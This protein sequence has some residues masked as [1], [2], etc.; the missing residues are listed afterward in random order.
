MPRPT[1]TQA[2]LQEPLLETG[3]SAPHLMESAPAPALSPFSPG[4]LGSCP[5]VLGCGDRVPPTPGPR[6]RKLFLR[7]RIQLEKAL[8]A[9]GP[10]AR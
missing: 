7:T 9:V 6:L 8:L 3:T 4:T 5:R 2:L 10:W 1:A